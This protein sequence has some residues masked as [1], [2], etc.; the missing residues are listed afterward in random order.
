MDVDVKIFRHRKPLKPIKT[1]LS[2]DPLNWLKLKTNY[3][4]SCLSQF[5]LL[6]FFPK[7]KLKASSSS[8]H[9]EPSPALLNGLRE[10]T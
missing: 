10:D 8:S 5:H 1:F 3:K 4:A 2:S 6:L 9:A 7:G